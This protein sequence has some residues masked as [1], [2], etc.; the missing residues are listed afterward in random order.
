MTRGRPCSGAAEPA[1][2]ADLE[3]KEEE[4]MA[5]WWRGAQRKKWIA[6]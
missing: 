2:E 3:E 1:G 4:L 6:S 5:I